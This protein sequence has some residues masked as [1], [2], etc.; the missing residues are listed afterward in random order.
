MQ[1]PFIQILLFALGLGLGR[2]AL[3]AL[4]TGAITLYVRFNARRQFSKDTNPAAFWI[5]VGWYL[6]LATIAIFGL[7]LRLL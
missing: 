4:R 1:A 7:L 3:V 5:I 6:L 2:Q